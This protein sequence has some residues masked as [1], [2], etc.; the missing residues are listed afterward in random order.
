MWETIF[1]PENLARAW[2]RVRANAGAPGVDGMNVKQYPAWAK[3]HWGK[4]RDELESEHYRP[5]PV[6]RVEIEKPDG[7]IRLLGVPTINDRVIQ[8]A[9]AQI[10]CAQ[11]DPEFHPSSYGFRPGKSAHQAIQQLTEE[12]TAGYGWAVDLDLEKF[13]DRV[14]HDVLMSRLKRRIPDCKVLRLINRYLRSGVQELDGQIQPTTQGV[15]QGGPLSPLLANILLDDLDKELERRGHRFVRYADDFIILTR[16][17]RAAER[18]YASI[19]RWLERSLRLKVNATKSRVCRVGETSYLGF[20]LRRGKPAATR[21]SKEQF[22]RRVKELTGRSW[23]VSMKY[24]MGKLNSYLRGWTNY[25]AIGLLWKEVIEWEARIR[26]RLRMCYWKKWRTVRK[27]VRELMKM[28]C[29]ESQA[30]KAAMSRKSFWRLSKTYATQLGMSNAWLEA[31][32]LV[33]I[34]EIWCGVRYPKGPKQ[35]S[36]AMSET[37]NLQ[38]LRPF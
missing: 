25:F 33:S 9:I 12:T 18:V 14:N 6:R 7:G 32:G 24:R 1:E 23:G 8:Q 2:K 27:R 21:E 20:E 36:G 19:T 35:K 22:K 4:V 13:F 5:D 16:S 29:S 11:L 10:L 37:V 26:R 28:G 15:P 34:K 3:E 31:E 38:A 17:Q 30:V